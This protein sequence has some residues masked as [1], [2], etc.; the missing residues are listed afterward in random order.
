[1]ENF[2]N[3]N[4]NSEAEKIIQGS[5][6]Y[7]KTSKNKIKNI[8]KN[9]VQNTF[10]NEFSISN[11]QILKQ[12]NCERNEM[13]EK[14]IALNESQETVN[15]DNK[16]KL[17]I[18]EKKCNNVQGHK[19][20]DFHEHPNF[21]QI[22]KDL[23]EKNN[24]IVRD[25]TKKK[26]NIIISPISSQKIDKFNIQ[27]AIKELNNSFKKQKTNLTVDS[28]NV[29]SSDSYVFDPKNVVN[30]NKSLIEN[31][32]NTNGLNSSKS[33][34]NSNFLKNNY[35]NSN[36]NPFLIDL[37]DENNAS[38]SYSKDGRLIEIDN[39]KIPSHNFKAISS[40]NQFT[41]ER[42]D[43]RN[44]NINEN[45]K[46]NKNKTLKLDINFFKRKPIQ[47]TQ[48]TN[49]KNNDTNDNNLNLN[50][51]K[52]KAIQNQ[53]NNLV[54]SEEEHDNY[55]NNRFDLENFNNNFIEDEEAELPLASQNKFSQQQLE[56]KEA[57]DI[58]NM[59]NMN[60]NK[61]AKKEKELSE[62]ELLQKKEIDPN[63]RMFNKYTI[64]DY[65]QE[66]L[67]WMEKH[68]LGKYGGPRGGII[69]IPMGTGKTFSS[70]CKIM[71]DYNKFKR[72]SL[73]VVPKAIL[74]VW[75]EELKKFF[76]A[77]VGRYVLVCEN[78]PTVLNNFEI[79]ILKSVKIVLTTYPFVISMAKKHKIIDEVINKEKDR[80]V[81]I[82]S[83]RIPKKEKNY[84][85]MT[86]G[87]LMFNFVFENIFCDESSKFTNIR[88]LTFLSM[89]GLLSK[90]KWCLT[91]NIIMNKM[92]DVKSQLMFLGMKVFQIEEAQDLMKFIFYKKE[93]E[94]LIALPQKNILHVNLL[95]SQPEKYFYE[96]YRSSYKKA[97]EKNHEIFEEISCMLV[98]IMRFRQIAIHPLLVNNDKEK[99]QQNQGLINFEKIQSEIEVSLPTQTRLWLSQELNKTTS[100]TKVV[101]AVEILK[102][103]PN[104]EKVIIFSFFKDS[105]NQIEH[106]LSLKRIKINYL[107]LT[108]D[109]K[110]AEREIIIQRFRDDPSIK[111]L[112]LTF[113]LGSYGL[114]LFCANNIIMMDLWWN[115]AVFDQAIARIY[116]N[117]QIRPVKIFVLMIEET[118]DYFMKE[119][120]DFKREILESLTL[121]KPIEKNKKQT[122]E[123][124]E[125][126]LYGADEN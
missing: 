26:N 76:P 115:F 125:K 94:K 6:S 113:S 5:R 80:I 18:E 4:Y 110:P 108:N 67:D 118:I 65:Q 78:K 109:K 123:L 19:I 87:K 37:G 25:D 12:I 23:I 47:I 27:D 66:L 99:K 40:N 1:M 39:I 34:K 16:K 81:S 107:K 38:E 3:N 100:S 31:I 105:F 32:N 102:K 42:D 93:I 53:F 45:K 98:V 62:E 50:N 106:Y 49:K 44:N 48:S 64:K 63:Y 96:Y 36:N 91:G 114:N 116:R 101:Q 74:S 58:N 77:S 104:D 85:N 89:M 61:Q 82:E 57:Y 103:I 21:L 52:N 70:L 83:R 68:S 97:Y 22:H 43:S 28:V 33:T 14:G 11:Y 17:D 126:I 30:G 119:L 13:N 75:I 41:G 95:F 55:D 72:P 79:D 2:D 90:K 117:G 35:N 71:C 7:E 120:I 122:R 8:V 24:F 124:F 54:P 73:V 9:L 10:K 51:R 111:V 15:I 56:I 112:F 20:Q 29:L 86:G 84:T 121:K 46:K 59:K 69:S 92:E 88:S 60:K